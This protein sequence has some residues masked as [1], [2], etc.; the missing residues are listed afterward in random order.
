[1]VSVSTLNIMNVFL[2]YFSGFIARK[3]ILAPAWDLPSAKGLLKITMESSL[4]QVN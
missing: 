3:N 2:K 1:M 4:L